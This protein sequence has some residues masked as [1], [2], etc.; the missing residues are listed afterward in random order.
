MLHNTI[1]CVMAVP[2]LFAFSQTTEQ[3]TPQ[4][5]TWQTTSSLGASDNTVPILELVGTGHG[6]HYHNTTCRQRVQKIS[7]EVTCGKCKLAI[8]LA[9]MMQQPSSLTFSCRLSTRIARTSEQMSSQLMTGDP[10]RWTCIYQ[11]TIH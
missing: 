5:P 8:Q 10:I 4:V 1:S 7:C 2:A 3:S 11:R 9:N 6:H